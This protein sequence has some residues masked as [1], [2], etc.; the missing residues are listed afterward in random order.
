MRADSV[1]SGSTGARPR[2]VRRWP[3]DCLFR[4]R[5][6][7]DKVCAVPNDLPVPTFVAGAAWIWSSTRA[8]G[9]SLDQRPKMPTATSISARPEIGVAVGSIANCRCRAQMSGTLAL[10]LATMRDRNRR[11]FSMTVGIT[12]QWHEG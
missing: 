7:P 11:S 8:R 6:E 10:A 4:R 1:G 12:R 2:T 3:T 9:P 5:E